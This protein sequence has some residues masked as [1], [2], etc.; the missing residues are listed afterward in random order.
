MCSTVPAARYPPY[1]ML[2]FCF[3]VCRLQSYSMRQY[4]NRTICDLRIGSSYMRCPGEGLLSWTGNILEPTLLELWNLCFGLI[5]PHQL[6]IAQRSLAVYCY[7]GGL[8]QLPTLKPQ[9]DNCTNAK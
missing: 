6:V 7:K 1:R 4:L 2:A 9:P 8:G 5:G 3:I